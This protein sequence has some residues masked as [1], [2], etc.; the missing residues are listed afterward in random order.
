MAS[1]PLLEGQR[2]DQ[3][4]R[5]P[6]TQIVHEIVHFWLYNESGMKPE[7]AP[8]VPGSTEGERMSNALRMVLTVAKDELLKK[9]ARVKRNPR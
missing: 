7:P 9:E 4:H 8:T 5:G 2:W 3:A 1:Q 6:E